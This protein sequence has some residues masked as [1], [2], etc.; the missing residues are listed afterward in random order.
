M[1]TFIPNV[2]A[3]PVPIPF[4]QLIVAAT[5]SLTPSHPIDIANPILLSDFPDTPQGT[6]AYTALQ[7][8]SEILSH[9]FLHPSNTQHDDSTPSQELW[10]STVSQILV[11]IHNSIRRTHGLDPTPN[12]FQDLSSSETESFTLLARAVSS[13]SS[14]FDNRF[15][16]LLTDPVD[17]DVETWEICLR[18]LEE[19]QYPVSKASWQSVLMSCAQ[20]IHAAHRTI[21]NDKLRSLTLETD[22]WVDARC[23][24]I[25]EAFIE[26]ISSDDFSSL[27]DATNSDPRLEAWATRTLASFTDTAKRFLVQETLATTVEPILIESLQAAKVK[28]DTEGE[29]YLTNYI[30]EE[31]TKAKAT[32]NRDVLTF[33]NDTLNAL[34]A[35]AT[36]RSEQEIA[37]FKST[38]KVKT[39]ER[40]AAL[41]HDFEKWAPKPSPAPSSS[42]VR[43]SHCKTHVERSHSI[44]APLADPSIPQSVSRSRSL[45]PSPDSVVPGQSL[46][47]MTPRASPVCELPPTRANTEQPTLSLRV[48]PMDVSV[49]PPSNSFETAMIHV[50]TTTLTAYE[51]S[52][53]PSAFEPQGP[54]N[55]QLAP[56]VPTQSVLSFSSSIDPNT[57]VIE[58]LICGMSEKFL[59]QIQ[60]SSFA[61][62]SQF[63]EISQ[64][65]QKLEQPKAYSPSAEAAHWCPPIASLSREPPPGAYDC[66]DPSKDVPWFYGDTFMDNDDE[67]DWPISYLQNLYFRRHSLPA[68]HTLTD[69]QRDYIL[70]LPG[71][72]VIYCRRFHF[73]P[74]HHLSDYDLLAFW[75]F[76][77]EYKQIES[78]GRDPLSVENDAMSGGPTGSPDKPEQP[79]LHPLNP[80][81]TAPLGSIR[82][83]PLRA[84]SQPP[85]A[86]I[87]A[88]TPLRAPVSDH[89]RG[90]ARPSV[91]QEVTDPPSAAPAPPTAPWN[92]MGK[93][94]KPRSFAAAAAPQHTAPAIVSPIQTAPR[95]RDLTDS[96][97]KNMSRDQLL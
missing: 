79:V 74:D 58:S 28:V 7:C 92:V 85:I 50:D 49:G 43:S 76:V 13:L 53:A 69:T 80:A 2:P 96:Q 5:E 8:V 94:N 35:E 1:E 46:D 25:R 18:C 91:A 87:N 73:S 75:N 36:E 60:E 45:A 52:P 48:P 12:A 72:F 23:T 66:I 57:S 17:P 86:T 37:E 33:Y 83:F 84:P 71:L 10:L 27:H 65:L 14:F 4:G 95:P 3:P 44:S 24:Q 90:R 81:P 19:C 26:A 70:T 82:L 40:K 62:Q 97:L 63:S 15:E 51:Y 6:V 30:H 11:H 56:P 93:G 32:A 29:E 39:E 78:E 31:R 41:L 64:R 22:E 47:Q 38:L 54:P 9:G 68:S 59:A 20:N 61:A 88:P 67:P 89:A 16:N 34:K 55:T 77:D 21:I 42:V